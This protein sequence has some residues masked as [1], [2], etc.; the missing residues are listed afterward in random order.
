V[1][2]EPVFESRRRAEALLLGRFGHELVLDH[3]LKQDAPAVGRRILRQ[4]RAHLGR[5]KVEIGLFDLVPVDGSDDDVLG[6]G[7]HG[8]KSE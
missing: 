4:L 6:R 2:F 7:G 3:E 8:G 1:I 5:G